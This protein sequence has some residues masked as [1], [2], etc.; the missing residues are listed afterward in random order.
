MIRV[1]FDTNILISGIFW[2]KGNPRRMIE[3]AIDK[4]LLVFISAEIITEFEEVIKRD[5]PEEIEL[6]QRHIDFIMNFA[7][8]VLIQSEIDFIKKDP[9]DNKIIDCAVECN[10]DFIITGDKYL[11][12]LKQFGTIKIFSP[13]EFL[14]F[15]I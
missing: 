2:D 9:K 14:E 11:L 4:K 13:K 5:F 6:M 15:F 10:A 3:L 8:L 1:V 12:S 7:Y